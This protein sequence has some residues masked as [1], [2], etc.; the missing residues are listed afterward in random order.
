MENT[1]PPKR[2]RR[3]DVRPSEIMEAGLIEFALRGFAGT[4][5][6]EVAK[7]AG[8]SEGTICHFFD[9]KDALF[10]QMFRQHVIQPLA[11]GNLDPA[12][13]D[14]PSELL[15]RVAYTRPSARLPPS[16]NDRAQAWP[17]DCGKGPRQGRGTRKATAE[18]DLPQG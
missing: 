3:K 18:G 1:H 7:R 6:T 13:L 2:E 15:L 16:S 12:R 8:V 10:R 5:V 17:V 14:L 9:T 11:A 4:A